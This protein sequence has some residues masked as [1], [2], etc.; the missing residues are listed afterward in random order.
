[1]DLP[2][3]VEPVPEFYTRLLALLR[4][5][6][7]VLLEMGVL[8]E[9][10]QKRLE[11]TDGL[12][13]RL[14]DISMKELANIRLLP[15]DERWIKHFDKWLEDACCGFETEAMK[16]TLV[17]DV[18]TDTN[19]DKTLQEGT[20]YIGLILVANRLPSGSIGLAAGPVFTYYEF[21][22]PIEDR[23]TDEKW[24]AMLGSSSDHL[25]DRKPEFT[26]SYFVEE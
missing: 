21:K 19:T 1:M 9:E 8:D 18:H 17:A 24:R 15:G 23:L 20:G 4:L 12:L 3:Y 2:G 6:K 13:S 22:H 5:T 14:L 10:I 7:G 25:A 11:R 26:K 16:P